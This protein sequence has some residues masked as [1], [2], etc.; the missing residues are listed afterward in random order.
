M[1]FRPRERL[2]WLPYV[3]PLVVF[4][5]LTQAE[6]S[7]GINA[8]P[9]VY[10]LKL[11]VVGS[12]LYAFRSFY[13]ELKWNSRGVLLA[14]LCG[15][16]LTLLWVGTDRYTHHFAFLGL[17]ESYNPFAHIPDAPLMWLFIA[18]RLSGLVIIAPMIEELF[19]R[20]FLLRWI[21]DPDDFQQV[22]IGTVEI[23]S[24]VAVVLLMALSH[25]EYLAAAVFSAIMNG[26]LYKTK[27]LWAT[28]G[29]HSSTNLVLGICVLHYHAWQYW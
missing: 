7:F 15:P 16:I 8:Y 27:N 24:F 9:V 10:T 18:I 25:P 13:P 4:L 20:G 6:Q 28:I 12:V 22:R 1:T 5:I 2:R 23:K 19:Y 14:V 3:L 21:I 29:A 26:I 17:R 11:L